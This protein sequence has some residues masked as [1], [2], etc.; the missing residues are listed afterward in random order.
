MKLF[1]EHYTDWSAVVSCLAELD[2]LLSLAKT[3]AF[4][5]GKRATLSPKSLTCLPT[6]RVCMYVNRA[7]VPP[8]ICWRHRSVWGRRVETSVHHHARVG[9]LHPKRYPV[10]QRP[11]AHCAPDWSQHGRKVHSTKTGEQTITFEPPTD[12]VC[13]QLFC[14]CCCC[15]CCLLT[16]FFAHLLGM[17]G[18]HHGSDGLLCACCIVQA[19]SC[20]SH[21]HSH[22]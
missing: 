14:C 12:G 20:R 18:S 3:S 19:L 16:L 21:L 9:F 2:C 7:H 22:R 10:G 4:G 17:R 1:D 11:A 8:W 6:S 15:C 5:G 13:S